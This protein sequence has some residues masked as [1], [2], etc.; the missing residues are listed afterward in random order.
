MLAGFWYAGFWYNR[1]I[2]FSGGCAIYEAVILLSDD[3]A[4]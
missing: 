3:L 4:C 1:T 2:L